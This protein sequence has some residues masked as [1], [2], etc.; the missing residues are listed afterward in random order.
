MKRGFFVGVLLCAIQIGLMAVPAYPGS[1]VYTQP[2]GTQLVLTLQGDEF[3]HYL[4]DETGQVMEKDADGFYRPK[5]TISHSQF[6]Q[7]RKAAKQWR[8]QAQGQ[9]RVGGYS[10]FPRGIVVVVAFSDVPCQSFTTQESMNEMCNGDNYTFDGAYGSVKKYFQDQSNG[11]FYPVFDVYG[12][13]TLSKTRAYYGQNDERGYDMHAEEAVAEACIYAHDS[14]GADFSRYD[15][16]NDGEVDFVYMIFAGN[17]ENYSGNP[18][19]Y[20]WPHQGWALNENVV[21][22]GKLLNKYACSAELEQASST[23]RCGIGVLC[24]EFSHLLGLPDTYDTQYGTNYQEGMIPGRWDLMSSG[25]YNDDSRRPANY[26]VFEKYQFGWATP[27]VL[28]RSQVVTMNASSDYY[29][30]SP[31]GGSRPYTTTD[32]MYYLENRQKIGWDAGLPGHGLM[33]WKVIYDEDKWYGNEVNDI[34]YEQACLFV[35]A[36]GMYSGIGDLGDPY[37]GTYHV[38][39]FE[40]P[41]TIYSLNQIME[42]SQQISFRFAAGCDGYVADIRSE[43]VSLTTTRPG[44]CYPADEPFTLTAVPNKNYQWAD[45]SIVVTMGGTTLTRGVDYTF[46]D[47]SVLTIPTLTGDLTIDIHPERI[48]FD[49]DHCMFFFWQPTEAVQGDTVSSDDVHWALTVQG[50]SYRGFD[51]SATNRGAQFGSRSTSPEYVR[52]LTTEMSNCLITDIGIVACVAEGGSGFVTVV[53]DEEQLEAHWLS[54]EMME[55]H[56]TNP[57]AYHGV[58]DIGFCDLTKALFVKKI[59]IHFAEETENPNGLE[60]V[61]ASQPT[62]PIIGIY[63]V[64]GHYMGCRMEALP[65]G[66]YLVNHTDGTEKVLV[67]H[68]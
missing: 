55:Y 37:P 3:F 31:D 66:L 6:L 40:V 9:A 51:S 64:T 45:T 25:N 35:P 19:E 60:T 57:E 8:A 56:F 14:L 39:S 21:L 13:I 10:P 2:D 38:T 62:G 54:E 18:S 30:V 63:S 47:D 53:L 67:Y 23:R 12:P 29:Y 27:T 24:H 17:G 32:T 65:R 48:P 49:Y 68:E 41:N 26:T 7:R 36:D 4:T 15:L 61:H 34:P 20:L 59:F 5:G 22:D 1:A 44:T 52:L 16:D 46:T 11:I 42:T 28:N 33:I 50:S 43:H 58:V